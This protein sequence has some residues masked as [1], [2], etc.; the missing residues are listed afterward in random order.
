MFSLFT[1]HPIEQ[2]E[3]YMEHLV[4]AWKISIKSLQISMI[5]FVHGVFPWMFV[6]DGSEKIKKVY[7]LASKRRN[8]DSWH[9]V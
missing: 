9:E 1:R 6:N 5:L 4:Q 2:D 8:D 3:T 7:N